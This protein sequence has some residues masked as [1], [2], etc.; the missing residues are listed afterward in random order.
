MIIIPEML[1][2]FFVAVLAATYAIKQASSNK[3]AKKKYAT[4]SGK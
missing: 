3:S 1:V 4:R 2:F